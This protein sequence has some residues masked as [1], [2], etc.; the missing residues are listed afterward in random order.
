MAVHYYQGAAES[1]LLGQ[2]LPSIIEPKGAVPK[3]GKD[4]FRDKSD[5]SMG[6]NTI[7]KRSTRLFTARDLASSLRWRAIVNCHNISDGYHISM[8]TGWMGELVYGWG[9]TGVWS[10]YEGDPE[11]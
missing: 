9:I 1:I 10:V 3:N 2:P 4:L 6:N 11:F 8:L 5:A 7:P